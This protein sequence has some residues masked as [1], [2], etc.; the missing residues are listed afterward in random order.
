MGSDSVEQAKFCGKQ[1]VGFSTGFRSSLMLFSNGA[2]VLLE[3]LHGRAITLPCKEAENQR[4]L[5]MTQ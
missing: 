3:G 1:P 5:K 2:I 4:H